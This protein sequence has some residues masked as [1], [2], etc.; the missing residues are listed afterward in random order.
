MEEAYLG[1]RT[2]ARIES[3]PS[4]PYVDRLAE[5]LRIAGYRPSTIIRHLRAADKFARWLKEH[6]LT[7][8]EA[9]AAVI[10][11]YISSLG[12][13]PHPTRLNGRLPDAAF[14]PKQLLAVLIEQGVV[15]PEKIE[16]EQGPLDELLISFRHHL[17]QIVGVSAGTQQIYLRYARLFLES[18][19]GVTLDLSLVTVDVSYEFVR[20]QAAKLKTSSCQLPVCSLRAFLRFLASR[21]LIREGLDR[22]VPTVR[23][24]KLAS[25][26]KYLSDDELARVLNACDTKTHTGLRDRAIL[27]LLVRLGLR[28]GEASRLSL[29]DIDWKEGR[30]LIRAGKSPRANPTIIT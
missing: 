21:H 6:D 30:I 15:Q 20:E 1:P 19:G 28:A 27:M 23:Q 26:P 18:L 7:L 25:L 2:G 3:G 29:D 12:R 13:L 5:I 14:G 17:D 22:A 8:A 9:N 16:V 10:E 4:G 11:R 24:W